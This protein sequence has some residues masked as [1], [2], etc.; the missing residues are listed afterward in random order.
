MRKLCADI[1]ISDIMQK[2]LAA[3]CIYC[4]L[5]FALLSPTGSGKFIPKEQDSQTHISAIVQSKASLQ[6]GQFPLRTASIEYN[7][8]GYPKFQFYGPTL[9]FL[10]GIIYSV[11]T[12]DNPY[13]TFKIILFLSFLLGGFFLYRLSL[14]FTQH[15]SASVLAGFAYMAAP[16]FLIDAHW[17]YALAEVF[18]LGI[19]PILLFYTIKLFFNERFSLKDWLLSGFFCYCLMTTHLITFVNTSLFVGLFI[20]LLTNT[21]NLEGL[22]R[23]ATAYLWGCLLGAWFL[24]PIFFDSQSFCIT[25]HVS[26][27]LMSFNWLTPLQRLFSITSFPPQ[28]PS[29]GNLNAPFYPAI[30]WP[31]LMGFTICL[32][33][34]FCGKMK[35]YTALVIKLLG[36]FL[37]ALFMTWSPLNFWQYLPKVLNI[38]QYTYRLLVEA[39]WIG[40][41]LLGLALSIVLEEKMS[42][43]LI[44]PLGIWLIGLS[45]A[46]WLMHYPQKTLNVNTLIQR[47]FLGYSQHS[48]IGYL[49]S[50]FS[51]LGKSAIEP[52]ISIQ[53]TKSFCQ[54]NHALIRCE[55]PASFA[56]GL[57]QFP[58]LYY[59]DLLTISVDNKKFPYYPT[60]NDN[61][62][63][64][65]GIILSPGKH[66]LVFEFTGI[67]WANKIS[68]IAWILSL[69]GLII[70]TIRKGHKSFTRRYA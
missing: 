51:K 9:Y 49:V 2:H 64:L 28:D 69:G 19:V 47:P 4:L 38:S 26:D 33:G 29:P 65:V 61:R 67:S 66:T 59:A 60:L 70:L 53:T 34:V 6:E 39:I 18:G 46:S 63:I 42:N 62:S 12:P 22:C 11:I 21:K 68:V 44:I 24:A 35:P 25:R 13:V 8:W 56:G 48:E 55:L 23:T 52:S 27:T 43:W 50:P 36:L 10:T 3:F 30:G 16:Y 17:R 45:S 58:V 5:A 40:A 57:T 31:L 20:L 41:L 14:F 54:R 7:G 15:F 32:F 37:L 1:S